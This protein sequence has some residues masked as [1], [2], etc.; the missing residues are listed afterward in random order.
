MR[1]V[2]LVK[3]V[4]DM[5]TVKFDR[6]RGVV[7]RASAGVE[8]N[9]FDLN[10]LEAAVQIKDQLGAEVIV[11]S[12]GPPRAEEALKDAISRGADSGYLMSDRFFGGA[13]VK[14]TARTLAAGIKKIGDVDLV[15][16]GLQTVDGDTGQVGGEVAQY[17][18]M[19][20]I[21]QV[22]QVNEV[23]DQAI[24]VVANLWDG[25]YVK[26]VSYP[27][28]ITVTKDVNGP[29]LPSFKDK[30]RARKAEIT[31]WG[32]KDIA[33]ILPQEELG[34]KG[35]PTFVKQIE[36]PKLHVREGKH[37][38]DDVPGAVGA[39]IQALAQKRVI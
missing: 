9:P 2:V 36:V 26:E 13:D 5:L 25:M 4:P 18:D 11:L 30:M 28:L 14:A 22:V 10:A 12:M 38:R 20:G 6:E 24:T 15:I 19:P 23:T 1:I 8:I 27:C 35:S 29:R 16:A 3:Q 7:D 32:A 33:D 39:V 21:C 17:L 34:L 31:V 37:Y